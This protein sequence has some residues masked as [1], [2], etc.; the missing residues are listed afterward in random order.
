MAEPHTLFLLPQLSPSERAAALPT[1]PEDQAAR[2]AALDVEGSW[3]VQAPAGAGKTELLTQRFLTL[4]AVVD[5][6]E[7][8]LAITFTR[9]ATAEMRGRILASL[10]EAARLAEQPAR[11][12][13][14]P[15]Q[16]TRTLQLARAALAHSTQ[17]GWQLLQQPHRLDVQTIDSLCLRL[18]H[19][20]PL[21]SR[22]GGRLEPTEQAAALYALASQRTFE[23][24]GQAPQELDAAMRQLLLLRDNNLDD[25]RRLIA[26]M[27]EGREQWRDV[28]V[29][30]DQSSVDWEQVRARLEAPFAIEIRRV[31]S[32]LQAALAAEPLL[33]TELLEL[34]QYACTN[35]HPDIRLLHGLAALPEAHPSFLDHWGCL[36]S[37]LLTKDGAWRKAVSQREGFPP[38]GPRRT[39][40]PS[41]KQRMKTLLT[42]LQRDEQ[43]GEQ[44]RELLC[45]LPELP[46]GRYEE[47]QW[48]TLLSVFRVLRRAV[49]EL[50]VVFAERNQVDFAEL[51]I[52][53]ATVLDDQENTRGLLASEV[54]RHLLIDEFQDTSRR[55]HQLIGRLLREWQPGD[56]RTC[57]LVGDPMQ[58]IY[59]FRQAEVELFGRVQRLGLDCGSHTHPCSGLTLSENFR[60][61]AGLVDPLNQYFS[62]IFGEPE[63]DRPE[64]AVDGSRRRLRG[65]VPFARSRSATPA[66]PGLEAI[67][68]HSFFATTGE[69]ESEAEAR[70]PEVARVVDLAA[71][72]LP[73]IESAAHAGSSRTSTYTVAILGRAKNH[74]QP[75]AMALRARG[76]PFRAIELESLAHRQEVIDL[77]SL[78]RALLHPMDRIAWLSV[79][80]AP[81]CGLTLSDLHTLTGADDPLFRSTTACELIQKRLHLLT[82]DGRERLTRVNAVL[83]AALAERVHSLTGW[84]ER[85]WVSLGAPAY[86]SEEE[87][88]NAA[89]FFHLLDGLPPD[90]TD[91]LNGGLDTALEGLY[92]A[93]DARVSETCGIQLMTIHKA[94]GLGFDV[95]I[96]PAL[97]RRTGGDGAPL[98]TMLERAR[99]RGHAGAETALSLEEDEVLVAPLGARGEQHRTYKWVQAMRKQRE[100]GE[101]KRLFYVACTRARRQLHLLGTAIVRAGSQKIRPGAAESLLDC[102]WPALGPVF[103]AAWQS[104]TPAR[105]AE[106]PDDVVVAPGPVLVPSTGAER[107]DDLPRPGYLDRLAAAGTLPGD[108]LDLWRVPSGFC[109][110]LLLD[111]VTVAGTYPRIGSTATTS[112]ESLARPEG[113][114]EQRA[115]GTAVHAMLELVSERWARE[116]QAGDSQGLAQPL[117]RLAKTVLRRAGLSAG[118]ADM[119]V[120]TLVPM[121]MAAAA[122]GEGRWILAPH[123][124]ARSEWSFSGWAGSTS[125]DARLRTLRV[126]RAFQA[127]EAPLSEGSRYLW[128]IDYK[129]GAAPGGIAQDAYLAEQKELW[130]PQLEAYGAALRAFH[131]EALLLRYGLYFPELLRLV[132]WGG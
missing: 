105:P 126:D 28:L 71:A 82:P 61:H 124:G 78:L 34:A 92:A 2:D 81:W 63:P 76:I 60:S 128:V 48:Q 111:N 116:G 45:S 53:A 7:E 36:R 99:P 70:A 101:R 108:T 57:F 112:S 35:G 130:K 132:S 56:K 51:S 3:I 59:I 100:S 10:E 31:L 89:T 97:E 30:S 129:T 39:A 40:Q 13:Q 27:L 50:H 127:G 37:F 88:E 110:E 75:I 44:L 95:V 67:Q 65:E 122:D 74:L 125:A 11:T 91:V 109:P 25:C 8:I 86:L 123:P 94:K 98:V 41:Y 113:S 68:M 17:R 90:G 58:S 15:E 47:T 84:L 46:A 107:G 33:V 55:Q 29:L 32:L 103:E 26:Q 20:Q 79:L 73:R 49:A 87:R 80:R 54:K 72:E 64:E 16:E 131:G 106:M 42:S 121:V 1:A 5:E 120:A 18:A 119:I 9:A 23:R 104:Q 85:T 52:A 14:P 19:G 69:P 77:Q 96:V 117:G 62:A 38:D 114:F 66:V 4:L 6:P 118:R 83:V 21:L 115:R 102:A 93:P 43:A 12:L 24:L 22:L